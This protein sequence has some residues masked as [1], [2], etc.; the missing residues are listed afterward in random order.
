VPF[1]ETPELRLHYESFGSG[2]PTTVFGHGVSSSIEDTRFLGSGVHGTRTFLH[3]RG[4]GASGDPGDGYDYAGV[5]R[6]LRAVADETG[7][8]AAVGISMGAGAILGVLEDAPDRFE[9]IVFVLPAG[10]DQPRTDGSMAALS[11]HA[12]VLERRDLDELTDLLQS[13]LPEDLATIPEVRTLMAERAV[14]QLANPGLVRALRG[15][16]STPPVR[17]RDALRKVAARCLVIAQEDDEVH[18]ASVGREIA[19][20]IPG[21]EL[22]VFPRPYA[23][24]RER[25]RLRDLVAGLLNGDR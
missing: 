7:A 19:D 12:E 13:G 8:T 24:L 18:P 23:M 2:E 21:C 4:H 1:V 16:P 6:D 25:D 10:L 3:F 15:L 17:D 5:T 20:L 9:R 11:A 14:R 22:H